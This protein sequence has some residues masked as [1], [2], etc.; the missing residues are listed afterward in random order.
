MITFKQYVENMDNEQFFDHLKREVDGL[1]MNHKLIVHQ[2]MND[3]A[4]KIIESKYFGNVGLNGTAL[5]VNPD[6]IINTVKVMMGIDTGINVSIHKGSDSLV[7]MVFP[8]SIYVKYKLRSLTG[9]DDHLISLNSEGKI[10]TFGLPNK[11]IYGYI[12]GGQVVR[13]PSFDP[14]PAILELPEGVEF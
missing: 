7:L 3:R 12:H 1:A 14:D 9:I 8:T 4:E 2:T 13:N 10:K 6:S 11:F 5:L